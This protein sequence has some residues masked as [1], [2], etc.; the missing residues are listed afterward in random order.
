MNAQKN[1]WEL[2]TNYYCA[3]IKVETYE[4]PAEVPVPKM[5]ETDGEKLDAW[6]TLFE[7]KQIQSVVYY[8]EDVKVS[9]MT[10]CTCHILII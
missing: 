3:K 2:V 1:V 6:N 8:V 5:P 4:L 10:H 9:R 7:E